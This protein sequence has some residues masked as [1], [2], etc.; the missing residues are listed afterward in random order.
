MRTRMLL[1]LVAS[2]AVVAACDSL[3]SDFHD[4]GSAPPPEEI[5]LFTRRGGTLPLVADGRSTDTLVAALPLGATARLVTFTTSAGQVGPVPGAKTQEVRAEPSGDGERLEAVTTLRAS[6]SIATAVV[7]ARVGE[8]IRY[9][10]VPFVGL[11]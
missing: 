7:S 8:H 5:L 2:L 11:P 9:L 3:L 10:E 6:D 4:A 1:A